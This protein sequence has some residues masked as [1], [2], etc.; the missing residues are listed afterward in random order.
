MKRLTFTLLALLAFTCSLKAQMY[1]S[2]TPSNRNVLIEEF[3]GRSC[4]YCPDGHKIANQIM[5]ANPGKVF[6]VN[7]HT[8]GNL[9]PTSSPNLNTS[10]ATSIC[11][12]FFY[13]GIPTAVVNRSTPD[14]QNRSDWANLAN[15]QLGQM[16]ECNVAGMVIVNP[17]TLMATITV[18]VYYTGNSSS[19]Q[20]YL[21]IAMTQDSIIGTQSGSSYNPSQVIGNSYCHM[22]TL[23]DIITDN[24]WGDAISPTTQGTLI[25]RTYEYQIPATIGSPNGV[26][27]DLNNIHFLAWVSERT[28][29][30]TYMY[31][32][33]PYYFTAKRPVMNVGQLGYIQGVDQPLYPVVSNVDIDGLYECTQSKSIALSI[34]NIGTGPVTSMAIQA[35]YGGQTYYSNWEV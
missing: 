18:E 13:D 17:V 6:C 7:L 34:Q 14:G 2:T 8:P 29:T 30:Y 19:G 15:T 1:V 20:N 25:T 35:E 33:Q 5:A 3:T 21:T 4:P 12:G 11:N 16:A 28:E 10:V 9:S 27:V 32:G 24:V 22:H 26:P 23:R 31:Q